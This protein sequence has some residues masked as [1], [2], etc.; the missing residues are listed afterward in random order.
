MSDPVVRIR[1]ISICVIVFSLFLITKLYLVQIVSGQQFNERADR[2]YI[3]PSGGV[4]NRG[5][6]FFQSK[7]ST[8]MAA[9][10]L[11][12]GYTVAINPKLIKNPEDAFT[13]L[14][15]VMTL[16]HSN[17]IARATKPNDTYEEIAK[18]VDPDVAK[19][20][21]ALTI[22]GVNTYQEKWRYYPGQDLAAQ[23]L[24]FVGYNK[25]RTTVSG[26][27]GLEKQYESTL[28]R[29]GNDVYVNFF[30]EIFSDIHQTLTDTGKTEGDIVST[31]E[32][33][34]QAVLEKQLQ[35]VQEQYHSIVSGG[36][37]IDPNTGEIY[38]LAANPAFDPNT[39][40][41]IKNPSVFT[42]PLVQSIY[43]MGS[44]V[45]PLT[46]AAGL[47]TGAVTPASTYN[48][49][50]CIKLNNRTICNFD[51]KARGPS[52][53]MQKILSESLNLGATYVQ[54]KT[55]NKVFADYMLNKYG[56][57]DQTGI[58][59]PNEARPL[60]N[61]LKSPRD[62][63]YAT[64]SFGQGIAVS[65]VAITRAL[66]VLANGGKLITPHVVSQ[67]DYNVGF[68]RKI[69]EPTP[70]QVLK[71]E[72]SHAISKMLTEVVDNAL[73]VGAVKMDHYSV[74]AKTGTAQIVDPSTG[75]YFP[76]QYLHSFFGYFPSYNPKFLV[77]L[78][79]LK[80]QGVEYASHTLTA[81]F[82]NI[83][84]FLINYY[85]IPPDR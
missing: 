75:K 58:D 54:Q 68:S 57:G 20:I 84:K 5:T 65:P 8:L 85:E 64:A 2:Q 35:V 10:S 26:Q 13:K 42:D 17:F 27:Y 55:G 61:N 6:I 82:V 49:T 3:H 22:S 74:A 15:K 76:N 34:V 7:D 83:E 16:D 72:T 21:N 81:P 30:A 18:R 62:V 48:D 53:P 1:I 51:L 29:S 41:Q 9:A 45:K 37:I 73:L 12:L 79:T 52:T 77:F 4:F 25:D 59:L 66:S 40:Q 33:S 63:E 19:S 69:T 38:A 44:I 67:I 28:T 56:L 80:P 43:E 71:P 31:I 39:F 70:P 46:M 36:I 60:V 23:A 47:D 24:G 50:G 32:P 78:Y 11:R 14:S